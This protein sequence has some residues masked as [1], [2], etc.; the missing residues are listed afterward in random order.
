MIFLRL[1]VMNKKEVF[2]QSDDSGYAKLHIF[3]FSTRKN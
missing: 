3:C 1:V 2:A